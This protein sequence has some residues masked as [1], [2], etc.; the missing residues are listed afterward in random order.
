MKNL[1]LALFIASVIAV[2]SIGL[3]GCAALRKTSD[4]VI[5]HSHEI[6]IQFEDPQQQEICG[7][8]AKIAALLFAIV[9]AA[10]EEQVAPPTVAPASST[11]SEVPLISP[12]PSASSVPE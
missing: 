11:P 12:I 9:D 1:N 4:T 8:A 3:V 2:V 7:D 5:D 6:C 10:S